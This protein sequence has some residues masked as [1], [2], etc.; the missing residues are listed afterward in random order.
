[1]TEGDRNTGFFQAKAKERAR[2]NKIK[3][4][5]T[6]SSQIIT[7]QSDLETTAKVFYQTLFTAQEESRPEVV[8]ACVQQ[9]VDEQMNERLCS[10]VTDMEVEKALFMMHPNKSPGPDGFTVGFYIRHWHIYDQ[11]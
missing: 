8:T 5:K 6:E 1:M 9:K 11:T 2:V 3:S 10:P 7:A 4:L